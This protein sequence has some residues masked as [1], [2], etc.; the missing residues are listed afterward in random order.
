[1]PSLTCPGAR[2]CPCFFFLQGYLARIKST[3]GVN[4]TLGGYLARL[5]TDDSAAAGGY[6][7]KF[8]SG[9]N[10]A[11]GGYLN[12]LPVQEGNG[13]GDGALGG[14]LTQYP[15]SIGNGLNGTLGGSFPLP[16][17]VGIAATAHTLECRI[18]HA[19]CP[20]RS[21]KRCEVRCSQRSRHSFPARPPIL[22]PHRDPLYTPRLRR[23]SRP[24][25]RHKPAWRCR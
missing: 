16:L 22:S 6:L 18:L 21:G 25:S 8:P 10:T 7:S 15:A 9:N 2:L 13:G 11:L 12:R 14:F 23:L 3:E 19:R 1:M 5:P 20:T 4:G 17:L 24:T